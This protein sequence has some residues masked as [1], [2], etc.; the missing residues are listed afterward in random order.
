MSATEVDFL[1]SKLYLF[2]F[3]FRV[4]AT[5]AYLGSCCIKLLEASSRHR[6]C[7]TAVHVF[8]AAD[9]PLHSFADYTFHPHHCYQTIPVGI[10]CA[11]V[12]FM[13]MNSPLARFLVVNSTVGELFSQN[14]HKRSFVSIPST[15]SPTFTRQHRPPHRPR[16]TES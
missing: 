2:Q 12:P 8:P 15:F 6:S 13:K 3:S 10:R 11:S 5:T 7:S 4:A 9:Y 14:S 1:K 16:M